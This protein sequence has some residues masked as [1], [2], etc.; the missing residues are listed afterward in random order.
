MESIDKRLGTYK[1]RFSHISDEMLDKFLGFCRKHPEI[2]TKAQVLE[3]LMIV[4]FTI[5]LIKDKFSGGRILE[6]GCGSGAHSAMLSHFG[7][8]SAT[9]LRST[10][11]WLGDSVDQTREAVFGALAERPIEF[12][13]NDGESIPYDDDSFDLVFHN[14]VIE[15]VPDIVAFN[16]EV[17]RV[18]RPGG[19]CICITGTPALCRFRFIKQ[20]LIKT[21]LIV[22]YGL[23]TTALGK[24]SGTRVAKS[25][26]SRIGRWH[27]QSTTVRLSSIVEKHYPGED[28]ASSLPRRVLKGMYP[29]MRHFVREPEYNSILL[30][31][32]AEGNGV[33]PRALLLQFIEHFAVARHDFAFRTRPSTHSQHTA[34]FATEIKEWKIETWAQTF[35]DAGFEVE[36]VRGYRFQQAVDLT[37]SER[38]NAWIAYRALPWVRKA[39]RKL[40]A[41]FATEIIILARSNK[42][43]HAGSGAD[44]VEAT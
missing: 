26:Y 41:R 35:V 3:K 27:F 39:A 9:E 4:D 29:S 37:F 10:V 28:R 18:L 25:L 30:K 33:T 6:I 1:N 40:P 2:L 17:S 8:V 24:M 32:L 16:R 44:F 14:S 42:S 11:S 31:R 23:V 15:H 13:Y 22:P 20:Y 38:A 5:P 12:R 36:E 21:P 34:N 7:D 19:I 43:A